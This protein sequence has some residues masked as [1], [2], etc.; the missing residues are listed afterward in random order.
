MS[1]R[2]FL[3][4]LL[5]AP[6]FAAGAAHANVQAERW[7]RLNEAVTLPA[8]LMNGTTNQ[9]APSELSLTSGTEIS[10]LEESEDGQHLLIALDE[11]VNPEEPAIL[12]VRRADLDNVSLEHIDTE[13]LEFFYDLGIGLD[14]L[15]QVVAGKMTYC[16]RDVRIEAARYTKAR[17]IPQGIPRAALAYNAYKGK[18]WKPI[19]YSSKV[20]NGT[21]CFYGGGRMDCCSKYNKAGKC[22]KRGA[23][24]GHA[25]IKIGSNK[26]KGA[27]IRPVPHLPDTKTK[28]YIFHGCLTP[29]KG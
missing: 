28:K 2:L 22:I 26:W 13:A 15:T 17:N 21:A 11:G 9:N 19:K 24:C 3:A 7:Y 12:W 8:M 6:I 18:G 16:L 14:G 23:A 10:I 5:L 1:L 27:G 4:S 25:A 20:P 29:P